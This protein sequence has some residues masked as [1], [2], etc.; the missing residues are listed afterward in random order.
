MKCVEAEALFV[1]AG[2]GRLELSQEVRLAG[3]LDGCTGCR[4]RAV[5]WR[6]LVP[7]M[8]GLAPEAPDAMRIRRMQ[9]E[10]ERRLA[11]VARGAHGSRERWVSWSAALV[12]A[13]A[14]ALALLWI[15]R[16][17]DRPI[18]PGEAGYGV[19]AHVDGELTAEGRRI[20]D[21]SRLGADS[22][23]AL[24]SGRADLKLGRHAQVRL[25]GPARLELE[26]TA[27]AIA[28][29]LDSG[30]VDAEVAHREADETFAVITPELRVEV[31]G[32]RFS[33]SAAAGRSSV[34]VDEGRVEVTLA[35]G[36]HRFVSTGETLASPPAATEASNA[37]APAVAPV[38]EEVP[39]LAPASPRESPVACAEAR[40]L[41]E[42]TA[43]AVRGSMRAGDQGRALR[44]LGAA[45]GPLRAA[46]AK[47]A[48]GR[49]GVAACEDELGYLRAE[50]LRGAGQIDGAI[51][52]YQRL[53][54]RAEPAAM[55]QNALYAAAELEARHGQTARARADYERALAVAP[56]GALAGEAMLG[57]MDSAAAL[58]DH[59]HAASLAR[60][61]LAAFPTG[62]GATRARRIADGQRP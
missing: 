60:R 17:A 44:Q 21:E 5:M 51:A 27:K 54:G 40:R 32:T 31:R 11:P 7:G 22:H 49:A 57:A 20:A 41:C 42:T 56:R 36:A 59:A 6:G 34:H 24:A 23:L 2:D 46:H 43:L 55:R 19:V 45:A 35:S 53:G 25:V 12:F 13:S 39:A 14:A 3:H 30:Q 50:A 16:P 28:L 38:P 33:V 18:A 15:R 61:Y 8:R 52:A 58:G 10:M 48:C 1:D 62:L 4:E 29:R 47:T 37:G 9:I 26:G